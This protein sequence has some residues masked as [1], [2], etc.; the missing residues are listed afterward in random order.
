[1]RVLVLGAGVVGVCTAWFLRQAG[2]EVVVLD[3]QA[4]PAMETSYANGGQ[5]S[6]S[7]AEPWA[8]PAAP[9]K[10]LKWLGRPDAP[11][12]LRPRLERQQWLWGLAFLRECRPG[13]S[14]ANIRSIL[15]LALHSRAVLKRLRGELALE[16]DC[17]ERGILHFYTDRRE[18]EASLAPA[19]LMRELGCNR[20]SISPREAVAL[21]PA[22]SAIAPRLVGADYCAEDESGDAH[23][24]SQTLAAL[25]VETGVEFRFGTTVQSI[26]MSDGRARGAM[27]TVQSRLTEILADAVVVCLGVQ[28]VPLLRALGLRPLI[29]P[30]KGY[31]ASYEVVAAARAPQVSLTDDEFKL[32]LSRLGNRL[33]VAGTAEIGAR[34]LDLDPRRCETLTRRTQ[35]LFPDACDYSRPNYWAGLRPVTPTNVPYLGPTRI[36]GLYLN[37]GH[38]TLGWTLAAGNGELIAQ[39][40][41]GSTTTVELPRYAL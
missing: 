18:F 34:G 37:V 15:R 28:A 2:H 27:A 40:I 39:V 16:Y 3:R 30:G 26:L 19:R 35:E 41:S 4:A 33:R 20:R 12:L 22:L 38:G 9:G 13:R 21:E 7:H 10:I 31:S 14:A 29:Y 36:P 6:A 24:F 17:A 25:C 1:M 23:R 8:N 11:L 32:V 5:I